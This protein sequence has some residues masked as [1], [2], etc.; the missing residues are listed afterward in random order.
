MADLEVMNINPAMWSNFFH[1]FSIARNGG[2]LELER[3]NSFLQT[4]KRLS[5]EQA[6][7][8]PVKL[9]QTTV[10]E[11]KLFLNP[12]KEA[13]QKHHESG[14]G[15][16][17]WDV[18]GLGF[19]E[20]RNSSV[21]AWLL[22]CHGSH[23]QGSQF[24]ES[25]LSFLDQD[26]DVPPLAL[27]ILP[28]PGVTSFAHYW[29]RVESLP[30]GDMVSRVDIEI[31]GSFILFIEVKIYAQETN[32]Q[33][34]RYVEI[35][36]EKAGDRKWGVLFLTRNKSRPNDKTL[37]EHV[38]SISWKQLCSTIR[39][40]AERGMPKDSFGYQV[41]RQFCQHISTL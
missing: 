30:L 11:F 3:W 7:S 27:E 4:F 36:K 31:E 35:A 1:R 40:Q 19:D 12:F 24:L 15:I 37:H 20:M 14:L 5:S 38:I 22:D 16:N 6:T 41:I 29:T 34:K 21:L 32:D 18:V 10:A 9:Q 25:L 13:L 39:K 17:V 33:L 2:T 26:K 23:G 28:K 8:Q